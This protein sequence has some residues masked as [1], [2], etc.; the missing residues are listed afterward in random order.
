MTFGNHL[1]RRTAVRNKW[2]KVQHMF[3][4]VTCSLLA[5]TGTGNPQ[6]ANFLQEGGTLSASPGVRGRPLSGAAWRSAGAG[7]IVAAGVRAAP[8]P[9]A[10]AVMPAAVAAL[11]AVAKVATAN[12]PPAQA[13]AAPGALV[14]CGVS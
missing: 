4:K 14:K 9:L 3:T 5:A 10:Q 1:Q 13:Q 11:P 12:Q 7:G 2:A 6:D 8:A